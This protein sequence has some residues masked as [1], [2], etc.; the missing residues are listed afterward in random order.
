MN[1]H[2]LTLYRNLKYVAACMHTHQQLLAWDYISVSQAKQLF[3]IAYVEIILE[4]DIGNQGHKDP[5]DRE[6]A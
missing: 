2:E 1:I 4:G 5:C 6:L 3:F